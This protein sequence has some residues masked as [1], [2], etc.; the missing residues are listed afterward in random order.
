MVNYEIDKVSN[1]AVIE[2]LLQFRLCIRGFLFLSECHEWYAAPISA[3]WRRGH[4]TDFMNP[5]LVVAQWQQ[6][7]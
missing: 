4:A 7:A 2:Y 1:T 3:C 6:C 5:A